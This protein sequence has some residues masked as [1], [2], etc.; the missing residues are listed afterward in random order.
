M[1]T[2]EY[3]GKR[4]T[5]PQQGRSEDIEGIKVGKDWKVGSDE[6]NIILYRR[7]IRRKDSK[8]YWEIHGFFATVS[9]ALHELVNQEVR[10]T[11]LIDLM[12]IFNKIEELQK[13]I[14]DSRK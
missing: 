11:H 7:H 13:E 4:F 6:L 14:Q 10:D 8:E 3:M 5:K 12:T 9:G 2:R 1:K